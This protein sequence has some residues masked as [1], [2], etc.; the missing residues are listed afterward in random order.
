V[1]MGMGEP[2]LNLD[3]LLP[4]LDAICD[5]EKIGL[6]ARHITIS[7]SGIVPGIRRLAALGRQWNLALSLHAATDE[8]RSRLIP[9]HHRY[10]LREVLDACRE[11]REKSSRMVTLEY[12][13]IR[14][15]NDGGGDLAALAGVARD[16]RAK[17]NLIPYNPTGS[18]KFTAPD[19]GAV[20]RFADALIQKGV[21]L[22]VRREMGTDIQAACGQLRRAA[23]GS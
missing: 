18:G 20:R 13:L 22:S 21:Q 2:L 12:A 3:N 1:V 4:A 16:L 9:A 11:Y 23:E 10:P 6:G 8:P 19:R 17:V 5:P 15:Q 14:G 7:T